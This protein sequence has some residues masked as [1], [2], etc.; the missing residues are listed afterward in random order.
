MGHELPLQIA[1]AQSRECEV[2]NDGMGYES[3]NRSE[4]VHSVFNGDNRVTH[5]DERISI[6]FAYGSIILDDQNGR[7][8]G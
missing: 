1:S 7:L 3:L 2:E 4:R 8:V 5:A 6:E